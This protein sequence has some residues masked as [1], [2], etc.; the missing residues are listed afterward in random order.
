MPY[1]SPGLPQRL[2][3]QG[4]PALGLGPG[5]DQGWDRAQG[6]PGNEATVGGLGS[7]VVCV[8]VIYIYIYIYTSIYIYA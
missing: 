5:P 1:M 8:C 3:A 7:C 6:S 4:C 2:R